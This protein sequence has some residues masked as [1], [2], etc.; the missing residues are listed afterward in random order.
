MENIY[1]IKIKSNPGLNN[2]FP[3]ER[4]YSASTVLGLGV[5]HIALAVLNLILAVLSSTNH[6]QRPDDLRNFLQTQ[7]TLSLTFNV[8]SNAASA[9]AAILAWKC[10][11]I[12]NNIKWFFITSV[13]A[14]MTCIFSISI[15]VFVIIQTFREI[16]NLTVNIFLAT[17]ATLFLSLISSKVAYVGMN[18]DYP[19]D[20]VVSKVGAKF[21]ISTVEQGNFKMK[22]P[23]PP[24]DIIEYIPKN[25][26]QHL[27]IENTDKKLPKTE[28]VDEYNERVQNFL[29]EKP[30]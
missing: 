13:V 18:N 24:P 8:I 20:M 15:I 14:A 6:K 12:D 11:Y 25:A 22:A 4:R 27:C 26:I 29:S 17:L 23:P 2:L 16:V 19:D 7:Q 10:W 30:I 5:F 21:D 1:K 3:S 28:S 9:A